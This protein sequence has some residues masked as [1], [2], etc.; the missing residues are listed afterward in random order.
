MIE[1]NQSETAHLGIV[2]KVLEPKKAVE[3]T[4]QL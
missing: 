4:N 2:A 1:Y 3:K